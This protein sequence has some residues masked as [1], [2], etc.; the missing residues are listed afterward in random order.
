MLSMFRTKS[1]MVT[2]DAAMPGRDVAVVTEENHFVLNT[3][4]KEIPAG[5]EVAVFGMGCFW[6]VERI[7]WQLVGVFST[8]VGY[9]AGYTP[10]AT[11]E[12]VCTGKTGHNE[13]VRIVFDP[14]KI[15]YDA[16]LQVFWEGHNPTQGMLQGNDTGTQYRSGIYTTTDAQKIAA[17]ASKIAFEPRL[18]EAG[19]GLITTEVL[20]MSEYYFAEGYHQQYLSKNPNGYCGISGTGV[21]CPIGTDV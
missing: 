18:L 1:E 13:V 10:N 4:L 15:S 17:N 8:S 16:L 6:G 12:E 9:S 21:T 3:P 19:F 20:P 7:F 11:Y 14:S 2:S 5:M